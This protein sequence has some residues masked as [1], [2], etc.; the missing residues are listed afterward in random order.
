[1][2][3]SYFLLE[4]KCLE[5]WIVWAICLSTNKW[6]GEIVWS[7]TILEV[8][9]NWTANLC[10]SNRIFQICSGQVTKKNSFFFVSVEK[11]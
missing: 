1:M 5:A 4:D 10:F 7:Q 6:K 9:R 11:E 3:K 2:K 8:W